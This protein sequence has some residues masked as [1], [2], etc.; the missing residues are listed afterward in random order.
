[1][2]SVRHLVIAEDSAEA[3]EL[4]KV[5]YVR[6][7]DNLEKQA[8]ASGF[9]HTHLAVDYQQALKGSLIAGTPAE[10]RDALS[11]HIAESGVNYGAAAARLRQR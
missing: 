8:R 2:G 5:A 11:R 3:A 4:A 6:W 1:M 9:Q 7:Q 10:V